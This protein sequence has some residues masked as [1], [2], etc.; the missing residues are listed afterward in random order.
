LRATRDLHFLA[1]RRLQQRLR[2]RMPLMNT[3]I[4]VNKL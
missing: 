4:W 3:N 2:Q 1:V